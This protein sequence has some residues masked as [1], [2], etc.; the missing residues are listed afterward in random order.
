MTKP[1]TP[2]KDAATPVPA[3]AAKQGKAPKPDWALNR[4]ERKAAERAAAGLP[5]AKKRGWMYFLG[6]LVLALAAGGYF[7]ANGGAEKLAAQKAAKEEAAATAEADAAQANIMQLQP[8]ELLQVN[9]VTLRDTLK[10]TGSLAPQT[11]L[12]LSAEVSGRVEAVMVRAGDSVAQGDLLVQIDKEALTTQLNQQ[13]STARAT[14]AQLDLAQNQLERTK[15]LVDRGISPSSE[16]DAGNANVAQLSASL[17]ALQAQV[18][19][20]ERNLE[21]AT[22]TAPFAG[23]IAERSV[24]AGAF[25]GTGA[26]LLTLVDLNKLVFEATAPVSS[27]AQ[28]KVGQ[29]VELKVEGLGARQFDGQVERIN[30]IAISGSRMLPVYVELPNPDGLLRGGMFAS[31]ELVL[32]VTDDVLGI[33]VGAVRRD[34]EGTYVLKLD[35][36][37]THVVRQAVEVSREWDGGRMAEIGS[38]LSAGDTIVS[39]PLPSLRIGSEVR[40]LEPQQ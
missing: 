29:P 33:P 39:E 21:H 11:Q 28:I 32:A 35:A 13:R 1:S 16:L 38:G 4:R 23:T 40:I 18:E 24:D 36:D 30:P 31:G 9:P 14:Q 37:N 15:N 20:A 17:A 12:H 2:E 3:D 6:V 26:A 7:Y 8:Y 10:V 25:V 22:I 34:S 27:S 5:P 19:S